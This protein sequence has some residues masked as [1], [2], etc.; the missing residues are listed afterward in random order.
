MRSETFALF[1]GLGCLVLGLFA[2]VGL[3]VNVPDSVIHL[4]LGGWGIAAWRRRLTSPRV[5]SAGLAI[6]FAAI[7]VIGLIPGLS[8]LLGMAPSQGVDIWLHGGA[9]VLGAYFAWRPE[10]S[11]EHRA[12]ARSDRREK[13]MPVE[14]ERRHGH[15]DRRLPSATTEEI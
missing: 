10:L 9:A 5:F 11:L 15:A 12:N 14:Q 3:P 1:G 4:V 13:D 6:V 2:L 8:A 7:A